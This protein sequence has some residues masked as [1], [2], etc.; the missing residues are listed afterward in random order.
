MGIGER[1]TYRA[2]ATHII[3]SELLPDRSLNAYKQFSFGPIS[4]EFPDLA[5]WSKHQPR[6]GYVVEADITAFYQYVDHSVLKHE[7]E[8]QTGQIEV[9]DLLIELLAEIQQRSFGIPQLVD[10][11]DWLSE[12]YIRIVERTLA[13]R[14]W[15]VWRFNDDFR[16]G[17]RDYTEALNAIERLDESARAVGLAVSDYK[18]FVTTFATYFKRTLGLNIDDNDRSGDPTDV[19][20]D[21]D[22]IETAYEELDDHPVEVA[23]AVLR[24]TDKEHEGDDKIDL[25]RVRGAQ[26]R[27][28]RRSIKSL[29]SHQDASALDYMTNLVVY[30]PSLTPRVCDYVMAVVDS[31]NIGPIRLLIS[32][33][34]EHVSLGEWQA[35]WLIHVCR[36][37]NLVPEDGFRDWVA[38]QRDHGRSRPLGAE[39]ALALAE[40]G[41]GDFD[42]LEQALRSEPEALAP[43]FLLG[44]KSMANMDSTKYGNRARAVR[45]SSPFNRI[46][47]DI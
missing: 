41:V 7:L 30:V 10:A 22:V 5:A 16:I 45:D 12:I 15:P 21:A 24:R 20:T 14:G 13:R 17:C 26:I 40:A 37:L 32:N 25:R 6:L 42:D 36:R 9:I 43:W 19:P 34:I 28:L 31:A 3:G 35:L 8:L 2:L 27:D 11:S 33:V 46:L 29:I 47:L 44:M 18:T 4:Y 38:A 39:A 1:V 23:M